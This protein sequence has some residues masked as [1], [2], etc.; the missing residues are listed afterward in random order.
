MEAEM[1]RVAPWSQ[2]F[3]VS[4]NIVQGDKKSLCAPDD[5]NT[6]SYK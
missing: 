1:V 2:G 4:S 5:Y 6:E 3:C